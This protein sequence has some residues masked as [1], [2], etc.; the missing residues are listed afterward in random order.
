M[1]NATYETVNIHPM[2]LIIIKSLFSS[3][4]CSSVRCFVY[5]SFMLFPLVGRLKGYIAGMGR[6][7][8]QYRQH[9]RNECNKK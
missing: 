5:F 8:V 6:K 1:M 9:K 7:G 4:I 2:I 3:L